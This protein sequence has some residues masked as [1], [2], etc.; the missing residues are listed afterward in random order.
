MS[1]DIFE[2]CFNFHDANNLKEL[3]FYPYFHRVESQQGPETVVDGKKKVVVCSNNYLGLAGHP[4]VIEASIEAAKKYGTSGTGSRLLNGTCDLHE[5]VESKFAKFV[6]KESALLFTTGHHSNLGAIS[7]LV[8]KGEIVVTDKLDHASIIDGC[9]LAFGEMV[10]FRHN[11]MQDLERL[12]AKHNGKSM[13]IVV[14][15]VFSMEGDIANLP[16]ISKLAKKYGARVFV[17]DA[18][19]LGVIGKDG[20]GTGS[21]FNMEE[22][23]DVVMATASKSLAS[24]GGFIASKKEVTD[25]IKHVARPMI[26]TASLPPACVGAI[27]A[28]MDLVVQEPE[29][30]KKLME[31]SKKM[32]AAFQSM[33]YET[34]NSESPI[35]P[36]TVGS[37][38]TVFKMWRMLF[39]EGV[40]ASPV[41]TPAVPEGQAIIRTSYMAT[42]TDEH[43][44]FI[45]DKF[46]KVG[47]ALGVIS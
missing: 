30:R 12:L 34:N 16:E 8:G 31:N 46:S 25:Y 18:H 14:D 35:I 19:S 32:K 45:L 6:N 44:D 26:F 7:S 15:G 13:L 11:D 47:K 29:R 4:K 23:V 2:K 10:R 37:D 3:G 9:R 40:F 22:D 33:G 24:I 17:D 38:L 1:S 41:V 39:D 20:R 21:H 42:H 5:K 27:D 36:L 28:A 43:L